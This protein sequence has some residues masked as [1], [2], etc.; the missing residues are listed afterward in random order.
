VYRIENNQIDFIPST[1][2]ENHFIDWNSVS[3]RPRTFSF[4]IWT[5]NPFISFYPD[6]GVQRFPYQ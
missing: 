2:T 6:S 3:V 4:N 1:V 5:Q